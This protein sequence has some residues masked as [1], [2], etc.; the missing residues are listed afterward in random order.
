MNERDARIVLGARAGSTYASIA[1]TLGM[2]ASTV[3]AVVFRLRRQGVHIPARQVADAPGYATPSVALRTRARA[4]FD[5]GARPA[6]VA[7]DT[8]V[9]PATIRSWFRQFRIDI[10]R[11]VPI[12]THQAAAGACGKATWNPAIPAAGD[13]S[14][15]PV[16]GKPLAGTASSAIPLPRRG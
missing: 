4:A 14:V 5:R 1:E 15:P 11:D 6:D 2:H 7:R 9:N 12:H 16:A 3:R 8:G 13:G 10:R